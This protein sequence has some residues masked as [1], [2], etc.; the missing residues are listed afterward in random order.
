MSDIQSPNRE[1]LESVAQELETL[2]PEVVFIGGQVGE[3]LISDL[4]AVRIRPTTDV[5]VIVSATSKLEYRSLE[6]RLVSLGF[7]NDQSEGAPICRW[8]TKAG[9][10]VDVIPVDELV[11][12]FSN[13]WYAAVMERSE[14]YPLTDELQIRIPTAPIFLATKW[15][16]F[17]DRGAGDYLGSH[18]LEDLITVVAGRPEVLE[19]IGKETEDVREFLAEM[20]RTCVEEPQFDYALQGALPDVMIV[21]GLLGEIRARFEQISSLV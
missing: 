19:E 5:D 12:G 8:L 13:Q 11:L 18:D 14:A 17:L 7:R 2:L 20:A 1:I 3:L 9:H 15:D 16:A 10:K 6:K 4:A 21:S